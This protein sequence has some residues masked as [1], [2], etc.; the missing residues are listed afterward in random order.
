MEELEET[1]NLP[2]CG[3]LLLFL[4]V[5]C[6]DAFFAVTVMCSLT[7]IKLPLS[8]KWPV[9]P[10][11][12]N[13]LPTEAVTFKGL[14]LRPLNYIFIKHWYHLYRHRLIT[15]KLALRGFYEISCKM[16]NAILILGDWRWVSK[17]FSGVSFIHV[18]LLEYPKPPYE[19]N[20]FIF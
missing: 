17:H 3:L 19:R 14:D 15:R 7:N 2:L 9:L 18:S 11:V 4:S 12:N 20:S 16:R 5:L 13:K 8:Y 1:M 10:N 6:F